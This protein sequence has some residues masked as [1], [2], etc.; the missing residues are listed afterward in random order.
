MGPPIRYEPSNLGPLY[1]NI[2][3]F[4]IF[5]EAGWIGYFQIFNGFHEETT[6]QFSMNFTGEY[7]EIIGLRIDALEQAITEVTG[8]PQT[9]EHWFFWKRH[10]LR[11]AK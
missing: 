4:A 11:A 10:N 9:G 7:S 2:E 5:R 1:A 3:V 8:L 6:L